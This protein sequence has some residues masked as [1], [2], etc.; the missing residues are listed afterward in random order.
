M[1]SIII[2]SFNREKQLRNALAE[3]NKQ[4][5]KEFEVIV[6]DDASDSEYDLSLDL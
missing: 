6:V 5:Y 1:F 4:L 3:L 2:H